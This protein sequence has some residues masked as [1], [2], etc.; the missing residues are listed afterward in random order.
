MAEEDKSP[1]DYFKYAYSKLLPDFMSDVMDAGG[2]FDALSSTTKRLFESVLRLANIPH[3][4]SMM[5]VDYNDA[6]KRLSLQYF[7]SNI[8]EENNFMAV[9]DKTMMYLRLNPVE[10]ASS[11]TYA[12]MDD[13]ITDGE[14][15][16]HSLL[17]VPIRT[18]TATC[19]YAVVYCHEGADRYCVDNPEI[20][21][22]SKV[23]YPVALALQ[24]EFNKAMLEHYLMSDYLT[25]LPNRDHMYEAIVYLI[26]T[27]DMFNHRFAL[28]IIRVNGL[29]NINNS[30]GIITGDLL[31]K[32]M[33]TIVETAIN[34]STDNETITGRLNGGDFIVLITLP[35]E[36]DRE[37]DNLIIEK[38]CNA[39]FKET[40]QHVEINGY[41]LYPFA[42]IGASIYPFNGETAEELLRKADLAKNEAKQSG[43]G[44]YMLYDSF[45]DGDAEE[46]LFLNSNLPTA[47]KTNQFEL[48]YQAMIDV[49]TKKVMAAEALIR[50]NH[51]GKGM[52][53]PDFFMPYAEKNA[54]GMQIDLLVLNMAC[55]QINA[56]KKKGINLTISV[57]ISPRHFMNGII[58]DS[59]KKALDNY[60]VEPSCLRI[61]ILENVL[62]N[63]FNA[64]VK[65]INDL[66]SMGVGIA[67]DDFGTGY[68]SLEYVAK[69]PLDYLKV[70]RSIMINI[71]ENPGNKIIM[72]T[73]LT[74]TKGMQVKAIVEG[75]ETQEDFELLR[76]M[77]CD[78][79]QGYLINKP[80]NI[81]AF[82]EFLEEWEIL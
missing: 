68:S 47:I 60:N 65:V 7:S 14:N 31:L 37:T 42:N 2:D 8:V 43:P 18:A 67:L 3:S 80:M 35:S 15:I 20:A 81:K 63:D 75:V 82:E 52:I 48:F 4:F 49:Q 6:E 76:A 40:N 71:Q 56:W 26:Q 57:N 5:V 55:K 30:L 38:C 28:M 78:I 44:T 36:N 23:I 17:I 39:V 72:E 12:D 32:A 70:D 24:C 21:F 27:A 1:L 9:L 69:L 73:I 59:V 29:R 13:D 64:M 19:G 16:P 11:T 50:W 25:G 45:M 77:D 74:L 79:A 41:K 66:R 54:Y 61:E 10:A 51:P 58:Y 62:L 22:L 53:F 33:G 46:V 34:G